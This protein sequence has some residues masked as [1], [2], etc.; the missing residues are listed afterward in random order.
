[1]EKKIDDTDPTTFTWLRIKRSFVYTFTVRKISKF[2]VSKDG[3]AINV[4]GIVSKAKTLWCVGTSQAVWIPYLC[5]Y[6]TGFPLSR[7][8]TY[9]LISLLSFALIQVL[10]FLNNPKDVDPSYKMDLEFW[11]CFGRKKLCLIT[12]EI[13]YISVYKSGHICDFLFAVLSKMGQ[14]LNSIL[15]KY[16]FHKKLGLRLATN[17]S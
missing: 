15:Y 3:K 4:N 10:P 5:G 8:T 1:M 13:W 9:N 17:Y 7:M 6:K 12:N 16:S 14:I 2:I 11:D